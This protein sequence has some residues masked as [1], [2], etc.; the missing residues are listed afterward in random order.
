MFRKYVNIKLIV[1]AVL[2]M[3][4]AFSDASSKPIDS[5]RP[6]EVDNGP[7]LSPQP[8]TVDQVVEP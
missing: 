4:L 8:G 6:P 7:Y 3:A 2:V 5:R 1:F